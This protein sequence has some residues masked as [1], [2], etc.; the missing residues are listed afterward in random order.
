MDTVR[1]QRLYMGQFLRAFRAWATCAGYD[2]AWICIGISTALARRDY[3]LVYNTL[4][5]ILRASQYIYKSF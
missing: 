5:G 3:F 2:E 4:D 1:V